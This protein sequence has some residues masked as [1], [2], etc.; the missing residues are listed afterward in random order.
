MNNQ[1]L[2]TIRM[3]CQEC[4]GTMDIDKDKSILCCPYCG[5][6]KLIVENDAVRIERIKAEHELEM[7]KE[8]YKHHIKVGKSYMYIGLF[9]FLCY[10]LVI[11]IGIMFD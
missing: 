2:N 8:S 4:G 1:V 9:I 3:I 11:V 7:Q 10:L 5:S 6:K